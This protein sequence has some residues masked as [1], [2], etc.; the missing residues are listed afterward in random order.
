M[1]PDLAAAAG[2]DNSE[3]DKKKTRLTDRLK[4]PKAKQEAQK[5]AG[6]HQKFTPP[7]STQTTE[8]LAQ[9]KRQNSALGLQGDTTKAKKANPAKSG[10]KRRMSDEEKKNQQNGAPANGSAPA[11]APAN[12]SAP[13]STPPSSSTPTPNPQ[14]NPQPQGTSHP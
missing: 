7:P 5:Q 14:Q 2:N 6:K 12:G 10:P 8:A 1:A 3:A 4:E 9:D 13:S 11:T